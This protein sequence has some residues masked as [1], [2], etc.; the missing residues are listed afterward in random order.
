MAEDHSMHSGVLNDIRATA[1][2]NV[3]PPSDLLHEAES[4][5]TSVLDAIN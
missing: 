5:F 3:D 1:T 4:C 2:E